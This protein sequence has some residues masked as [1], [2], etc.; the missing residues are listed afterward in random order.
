MLDDPML[1]PRAAD[2]VREQRVNAEWAVQQVFHEFSAVFDE[3]ADPVPA[4]AEGRRRRSGR[5]PA[6][7]PAAGR[8][9]AA[10]PAARARRVV[11]ADRRRADAVDRGAGRLDEGPRLRDRRRQPD[12]SHRDPRALARRARG[13][14]PAQRER[15]G[16]GRAARRH[17]R[18][19]QRGDPRSDAEELGARRAA[20]RRSPAGGD[21]RRRAPAAGVDRRRRARSGSTRTSSSPTTSPRRA[22]PAPKGI[23]LY[24]SEFLVTSGVEDIRDED[25]QYEI[26]RGMLE[27]MAPGSVTVRTFDVDEE[28]LASRL[29]RASARRRLGA[30]R[31]A[32]E[33]AGAARP[34]PQPDAARA[35]PG[36]AARAAARGAARHAAH[37]VSVRL[38]RRADARG[39]ARWSPRRRPIST[40]RGEHGAA[41]ADRRDDRDSGGRLHGRSA[42]ARGRLLHHRHQRSHPGTAWRSIAPTSACRGC[43]SRC[44]RRSCG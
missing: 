34:A 12:V 20:R 40:R 5:P 43:T 39:A 44:T 8:R 41:R 27:G 35:V 22:T 36:P 29:S 31:G 3:V 6:D 19:R 38:E 10:R 33:P 32:G 25:R 26:Y 16:A 28:Q 24:R 37:H 1:L 2:I 18:H 14:R 11:G 42:G 4:R 30:G 21:G 15:A 9:D 23:G 13:R 7:E 17:R